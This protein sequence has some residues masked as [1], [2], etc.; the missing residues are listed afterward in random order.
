MDDVRTNI[1]NLLKPGKRRRVAEEAQ[2]SE[3]IQEVE[4]PPAENNEVVGDENRDPIQ[5][6]S[7]DEDLDEVEF[8]IGKTKR[9][10]TCLWRKGLNFKIKFKIIGF[11][12]VKNRG[13]YWRC[14]VED[15]PATAKVA[16][17]EGQ[18]R[19]THKI[20]AHNHLP[21]VVRKNAER[22]RT[23]MKRQIQEQPHVKKSRIMTQCRTGATTETLVET[24]NDDALR[25]ML[26][27]FVNFF[28]NKCEYAQ[29]S[30]KKIRPRQSSGPTA[31]CLSG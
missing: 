7:D 30:R 10:A 23:E 3:I 24:G 9:N 18:A 6:L 21:E 15:C 28:I 22:V 20:Q 16:V 19:G 1:L 29:C 14:S 26:H 4:P 13:I 25:M 11:R 2:N 27:R 31:D 17:E 5:Q 12:Y 8:E